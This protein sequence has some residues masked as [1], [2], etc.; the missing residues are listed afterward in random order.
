MSPFRRQRAEEDETG[1]GFG[2]GLKYQRNVEEV[3]GDYFNRVDY[4]EDLIQSVMPDG[5]FFYVNRTWRDTLGYSQEEVASLTFLDVLHTDSHD[6]CK[7]MFNALMSGRN[8]DH[9]ECDFVTKGG[10][11]VNVSGDVSCHF[12]GG[13]PLAT[14]GV[15]SRV[16]EQSDMVEEETEGE[17][18]FS[19]E[20]LFLE[21][22]DLVSG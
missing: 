21:F 22:R 20:E 12:E 6:H 17:S 7:E 9:V 4:S 8:F 14:R 19:A 5:R 2:E 16:T 11:R 13:R 15:F 3:I 18:A 1:G 10:K